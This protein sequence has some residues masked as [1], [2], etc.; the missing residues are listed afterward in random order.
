MP[1]GMRCVKL[2]ENT[3]VFS[4]KDQIIHIIYVY[5][6]LVLEYHVYYLWL[7]VLLPY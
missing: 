5:P 3:L 6:N 2:E 4:E 1:V 7:M